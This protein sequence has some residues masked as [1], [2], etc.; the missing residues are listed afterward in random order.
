MSP[1]N[2]SNPKQMNKAGGILLLNFKLYFRATVNKT[3]W[4][5]YKKDTLTNGIEYRGLG[6]NTAHLQPSKSFTNLTKM[7]CGKD[8]LFNKWCWENWLAICR[9]QKLDYLLT[10][11]TKINPKRIKDLNIKPNTIKTL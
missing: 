10:P 9:K 3:T 2:Q 5:W 4:H 11:Y 7:Q 8:P 6:S 1:N